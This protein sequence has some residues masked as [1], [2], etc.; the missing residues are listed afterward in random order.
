MSL[1]ISNPIFSIVIIYDV[2]FT[3][4]ESDFDSKCGSRFFVKSEFIPCSILIL[5][6]AANDP[7]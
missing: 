2:A 4:T 7:E 6:D 3:I 1:V 5:S